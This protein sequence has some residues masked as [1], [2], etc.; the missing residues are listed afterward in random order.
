MSNPDP[1][2][3]SRRPNNSPYATP[4]VNL[5][6]G[7][8]PQRWPIHAAFVCRYPKLATLMQTNSRTTGTATA[9]TS[10]ADPD[11]LTLPL[12]HADPQTAHT[13]LHYLATSN[14]QVL[15]SADAVAEYALALQ[16]YAAAGWYEL[17][18]LRDLAAGEVE[19]LAA[20][21][22][23]ADALVEL[24][25]AVDTAGG[26]EREWLLERLEKRLQEE[27][28]RD[29]GV[30]AEKRTWSGFSP[31]MRT[32]VLAVVGLERGAKGSQ[33]TKGYGE[34]EEDA[35]EGEEEEEE[36]EAEEE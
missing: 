34:G 17:R 4:V 32:L 28:S 9:A 6:F 20:G 33:K 15:R 31:F 27:R 23:L 10:S 13:V 24:G 3:T 12:P 26:A 14:Y 2:Q 18:G 29:A 1:P 25:R 36:E 22:P 30:F 5:T 16:T 21:V 11:V 7:Q 35:G 19:R 8:S